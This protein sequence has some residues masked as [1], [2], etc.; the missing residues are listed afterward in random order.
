MVGLWPGESNAKETNN[1][2]IGGSNISGTLNNTLL[3]LDQTAKLITGHVHSVEIKETVVSLNIL[4]TKLDL[5][6][7]N[8]FILVQVTERKLNNTSFESIRGDLGSLCFGDESLT[9]LL[10]RENGWS[11]EFVPFFLQE[12]VDD[13]LTGSLLALCEPLILALFS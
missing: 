10:G 3:L 7:A 6:V 13:L 2:S 11:N 4:Y 1:V 5:T 12:G 8:F 9:A